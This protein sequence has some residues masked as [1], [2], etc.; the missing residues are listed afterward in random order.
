MSGEAVGWA[1]RKVH[2]DDSTAKFVLVAICNYANEEDR[3][4]PSHAA[5]A[6]LTG[7]SKRTIQNS[8]QK[9]EDWG[10]IKRDRRDRE[11]GSET[12]AMVS[13]DLE[14][15]WI[16]KGG[17]ATAAIGGVQQL[18]RGIAADSTLET[19]DK[20]QGKALNR[21]KKDEAYSEDFLALWQQYPRT[22]NTSKKDA[23]NFYR[24]M[25]DEK[26]EMVRRA[27]PL[28]AAAMRAEARTEDKIMHMIRFLRG[29]VYETVAPPLAPAA[30]GG[31]A[32]PF[33]ETAT[34]QDWVSVLRQWSMNWNWKA[35]WGPEPENP[36]RPNPAGA[37]KHHVP[38]DILDRFDLKYRGH[39]YSPAELAA[40][41]ARVNA[42]SKHAVDKERAA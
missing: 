38:Q 12:S 14:T 7:L 36:L 39:L 2:M 35:Y 31:A 30:A 28:F 23:W 20:P 9:L 22:R 8:I 33:W 4:W 37:P 26:Q 17:I 10:I 24:V 29:G 16:V 1:F 40:I 5:I 19:K 27:V 21:S 3:A 32:K 6:R 18:P 42:A 13:I 15:S 34:R 41:Q 11:N 25:T